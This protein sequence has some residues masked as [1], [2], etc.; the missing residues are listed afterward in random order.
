MESANKPLP[1]FP[2]DLLEW[3]GHHSGG[4]KRLFDPSSG[5]PGRNCCAPT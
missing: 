1:K 3:A 2:K 4:V 5:R